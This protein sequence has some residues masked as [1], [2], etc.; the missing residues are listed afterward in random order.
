MHK[1]I[2]SSESVR[3]SCVCKTFVHSRHSVNYEYQKEILRITLHITKIYD[4]LI[5][6]SELYLVLVSFIKINKM[7]HWKQTKTLFSQ[8]LNYRKTL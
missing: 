7:I 4:M 3:K 2:T 5:I 8:V 1:H 6:V